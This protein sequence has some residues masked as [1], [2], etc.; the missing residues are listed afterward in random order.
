MTAADLKM[1]W[2]DD[3]WEY[4]KQTNVEKIVKVIDSVVDSKQIIEKTSFIF[5]SVK[6]G[7]QSLISPLFN[8]NNTADSVNHLNEA[9]N[10]S[11]PLHRFNKYAIYLKVLKQVLPSLEIVIIETILLYMSNTNN[12]CVQKY[13]LLD[14]K[15]DNIKFFIKQIE[16]D[17]PF[18]TLT[19]PINTSTN[20]TK[21]LSKKIKSKYDHKSYH[22]YN[23]D[24][25]SK[26]NTPENHI[27]CS[28]YFHNNYNTLINEQYFIL[29]VRYLLLVSSGYRFWARNEK[30]SDDEIFCHILCQ[31]INNTEIKM[32]KKIKLNF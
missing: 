18:K 21:E 6:C 3:K 17:K 12:L 23:L 10:I 13:V 9:K 15:N 24:N 1:Y 19:V 27:E 25:A 22:S 4:D 30:K 7:I 5:Q 32:L 2:M 26:V 11:K 31:F 28:V 29:T 20:F 16:N 14:I 8:N